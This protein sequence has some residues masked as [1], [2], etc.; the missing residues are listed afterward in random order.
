[1]TDH[2]DNILTEEDGGGGDRDT[3]SCEAVSLST[4]LGLGAMESSE[5]TKNV[6]TCFI[7][8]INSKNFNIVIF[9]F[10]TI[11]YVKIKIPIII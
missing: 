8:K 1:M 11:K 5:P 6:H 2:H 3:D 9:L 4:C 7:N 10:K